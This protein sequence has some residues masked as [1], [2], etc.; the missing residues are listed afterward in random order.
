MGLRGWTPLTLIVVGL[1]LGALFWVQ[2]SLRLVDLSLDLY[3]VAFKFANPV[4]VPMLLGATL[5]LGLL[6]G[7]I[8]TLLLRRSPSPASSGP[9]STSGGGDLW[10]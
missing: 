10:T 2:N 8:L 7:V 4:P 6:L 5:G 9:V 1:G 3:F